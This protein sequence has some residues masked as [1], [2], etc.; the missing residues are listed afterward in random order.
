VG[1]EFL[2]DHLDNAI[3]LIE[4]AIPHIEAG[5]LDYATLLEVCRHYRVEAIIHVLLEADPRAFHASLSRGAHAFLAGLR[6]ID[7]GAIIASRADPLFDAIA[8]GD[9]DAA[10]EISRRLPDRPRLDVEYEE[11][12]RFV[13]FVAGSVLSSRS[14]AQTQ[15]FLEEWA[16][17]G[18]GAPD[19]RLAVCVSLAARDSA[20]FAEGLGE[21]LSDHR[22]RYRA[23]AESGE[24]PEEVAATVPHLCIPG[25]AL[26]RMAEQA[27]LETDREYPL[28][29]SMVRG[30]RQ[31]SYDPRAW[32]DPSR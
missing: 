27:G 7:E 22:D 26:I 11:D 18:E 28:V 29:P 1:A 17:L 6:P 21:F 2:P 8:C 31:S 3:D 25:L 5:R 13:S 10:M 32:S 24:L 19:P 14:E 20:A 23:R 9:E 12:F 4:E 15:A 16:D 30:G